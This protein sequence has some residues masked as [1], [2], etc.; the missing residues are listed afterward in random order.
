M[1]EKWVAKYLDDQRDRILIP[2]T[3]QCHQIWAELGQGR[4]V[5]LGKVELKGSSGT[6]RKL[7]LRANLGTVRADAQSV[8]SQGELF[9]LWRWPSSFLVPRPQRAHS[10]SWFSTIQFKRWTP[11]TYRAW[12]GCCREPHEDGR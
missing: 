11:S 3:Q 5:V 12:P 4:G 9:S 6:L 8:M 7:S 1:A 2:Y 10:A